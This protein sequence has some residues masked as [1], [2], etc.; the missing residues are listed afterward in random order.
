MVLEPVYEG[1]RAGVR[2]Y[3]SWGSR[4]GTRVLV[5]GYEGGCEDIYIY[6]YIYI[7]L[8]IYITYILFDVEPW[9]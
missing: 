9:H 2:W 8:Y 7:Y 4:E 1:I 6:I 5:S 3:Y